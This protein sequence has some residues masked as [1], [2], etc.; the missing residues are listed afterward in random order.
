MLIIIIMMSK[1]KN[2]IISTFKRRNFYSPV[3]IKMLQINCKD[4]EA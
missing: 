4:E 1:E 2:N 3:D